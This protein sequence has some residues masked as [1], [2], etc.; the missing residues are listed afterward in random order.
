MEEE[1]DSVESFIK[2]K[3]RRKRKLK[4]VGEKIEEC[5]DLTETKIVIEFND[6]EAASIKS[7][8]VTVTV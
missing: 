5:F 3:D 4:N 8:A 1:I 6:H 7:I 2:S